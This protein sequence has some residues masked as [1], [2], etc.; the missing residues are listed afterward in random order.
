MC[1]NWITYMAQRVDK[2]FFPTG[3]LKSKAVQEAVQRHFGVHNDWLCWHN[4]T[5]R[6]LR[7]ADADLVGQFAAIPTHFPEV[8]MDNPFG[9]IIEMISLAEMFDIAAPSMPYYVDK[10]VRG[11]VWTGYHQQYDRLVL[12]NKDKL[13]HFWKAVEGIASKSEPCRRH[14]IH[15]VIQRNAAAIE[16]LRSLTHN[17]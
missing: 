11:V 8:V 16:V 12:P 15:S 5:R 13:R 3:E 10:Y 17:E 7:K 1:R 4:Q 14:G 6:K 2:G 9:R